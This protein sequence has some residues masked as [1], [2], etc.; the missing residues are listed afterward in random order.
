MLAALKSGGESAVNAVSET[1]EIA[2]EA[3]TGPFKM[4]KLFGRGLKS[5]AKRSYRAGVPGVM[6]AAPLAAVTLPLAPLTVPTHI[7][8]RAAMACDSQMGKTAAGIA[9]FV[10]G[11][12]I[13][14][15]FAELALIWHV[16]EVWVWTGRAYERVLANREK[17]QAKKEGMSVEELTATMAVD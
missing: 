1:G 12:L 6:F 5:D 8:G 13:V 17:E 10:G 16:G 11:A 9:G 7:A 3:L 2:W 14:A 4:L 15:Y